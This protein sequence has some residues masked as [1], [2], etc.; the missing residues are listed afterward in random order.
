MYIAVPIASISPD[1]I[2]AILLLS[3]VTVLVAGP[4]VYKILSGEKFG[5][6]QDPRFKRPNKNQWQQLRNKADQIIEGKEKIEANKLYELVTTM[7]FEIEKYKRNKGTIEYENDRQRIKKLSQKLQG[8]ELRVEPFDS[9]A[10]HLKEDGL[11]EKAQKLHAMIHD[12]S[13]KNFEQ[14][15]KELLT[16]LAKIR[17]ENQ[18][19]LNSEARTTLKQCTKVLRHNPLR[20]FYIYA[21]IFFIG[22]G[23]GI[24]NSIVKNKGYKFYKNN[25]VWIVIFAIIIGVPALIL[26]IKFL[27][28]KYSVCENPYQSNPTDRQ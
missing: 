7:H 14:T 26:V 4:L 5:W 1:A 23:L 6:F 8:M 11:I 22:L 12:T 28:W 16:E 19:T 25:P 9:L 20:S 2:K 24:Y 27:S 21:A 3:F 17:D 13:S 15:K 10:K 18:T